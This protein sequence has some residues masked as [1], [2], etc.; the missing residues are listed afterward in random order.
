[1]AGATLAE[2]GAAGGVSE[3]GA[4]KWVAESGG[5][6]PDLDEPSGRFLSLAEREEIAAG[7][8]AGL[9]RA[10]IARRIGRHRATVGRELRRNRTVRNPTLPPRPD[11]TARPPGPRPGTNRGRDRPQYEQLR[12]RASVAQWKAEARARRPKPGK[13]A[14]HPHLHRRVTDDLARH[15]SPRQITRRLRSDFPDRPEMW[16]SHETIYQA[17]YVQGRG[18][19]R[20]ELTQCLRTGRAL[21]K[22]RRIPGEL[23]GK[24]SIPDTIMISARPAE[25]NDRA[26]P[27][28]WEGDLIIGKDGRSAIGTLVERTTRYLLLL[29]LPTDHSA[30]TVRE[31]MLAAIRTLPQHLWRSLT[32]DQGSEM[33]RHAEIT[34]ATGLDIYFCDPHSPWQRGSNENT[35]GLLRA[36]Y[37]PKATNLAT[38]T[39]KHLAAVAAELNGRPRET[40]NWQTPAEALH[41]LLSNPTQ[42]NGVATTP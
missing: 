33:A 16:V 38:H 28:H 14:T 26:I 18:E 10:Q 27:G 3:S 21:R 8:H 29:H 42:T 5:M 1:M 22:P 23:R 15:W 39:P 7:W 40:L 19:L 37:F 25:A 11:G 17:L 34:L 2:A 9:S 32:W 6:I 12:Y 35:N 36:N 41:Q 24:R 13:L 30:E 20:R 4:I 31:A